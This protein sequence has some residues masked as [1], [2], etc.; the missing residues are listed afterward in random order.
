MKAKLSLKFSFSSATVTRILYVV[1]ILGVASA[2]ASTWYHLQTS[3]AK[4]AVRPEVEQRLK[5]MKEGNINAN[6]LPK[7]TL[8][9]ENKR[10]GPEVVVDPNTLGK[11]NP[12]Q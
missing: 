7:L 9:Q 11:P 8:N 5:S 10:Q 6:T 2:V 1:A 4:D 3:A 12:F